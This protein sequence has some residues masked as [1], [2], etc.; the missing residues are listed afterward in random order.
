MSLLPSRPDASPSEDAGPRV[1][2]V[3]SDD[4][5]DVLA[6]LSSGT[7]RE[8]LAA[9]HDEPAPPSE[10]ADRVDT[11]LQNVQYHL[12]KLQNAGAIEVV[13]TAYSAKGREM[14]VFA[15]AD[16]PL[17]I[18]A[19]DDDEGSTLRTALK[20]LLGA[21]GI[22]ALASLT[23][24]AIFG[25][26]H[27]FGRFQ[28]GLGGAPDG[29]EAP[30]GG[31]ADGGDGGGG[32]D[33]DGGD[34]ARGGDGSDGDAAIADG[35]GDGGAPTGDGDAATTF[36]DADGGDA[37]TMTPTPGGG[38]GADGAGT[39]TETVSQAT[40][41]PSPTSPGT[42]TPLPTTTEMPTPTGTEMPT[43]TGTP[44]EFEAVRTTAEAAGGGG[45]PPGLLFFA[46]G[47]FALAILALVLTLR[48]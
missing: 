33:A 20:R 12:D 46:G 41:T 16:Q 42:E 39:V 14:D 11:S 9:L 4:A 29:G 3:D 34:G 7:A 24:Q 36:A 17:V 28:F 47:L 23:V 43:P 18:F 15:P 40:G 2:G 35:D 22:L 25:R 48:A 8:L 21:V 26:E 19:G 45:L 1:I 30:A 38:D 10:L 32:G 31:G 44:E 37:G 27:L 6:A 5:D 13:D